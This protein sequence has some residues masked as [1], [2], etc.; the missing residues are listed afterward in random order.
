MRRSGMTEINHQSRNV[1][2]DQRHTPLFVSHH[3]E[4][5]LEGSSD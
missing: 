5:D 3:H 4:D 1:S 2:P